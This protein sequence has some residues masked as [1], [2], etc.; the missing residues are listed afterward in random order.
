MTKKCY[1]CKSGN[2]TI[3]FKKSGYNIL[4]CKD[5]ALHFLDFSL[6]YESFIVDFYGAGY[7]Q[8]DKQRS[9][10]IDYE[11][12]SENVR[13]AARPVLKELF[14]DLK[15]RSIKQSSDSKFSLLDIGCANG[16]LMEEA[17]Q[18]GFNVYGIDVSDFAVEIAKKRF[19]NRVKCV[20][21]AKFKGGSIRYDAAVMFD[22]FEHLQNP[23]ENLKRLSG[24][25]ANNGLLAI[26][27]GDQGSLMAKIF[28]HRW[29]F[30]N[31]PQ[32]LFFMKLS[33]IKFLLEEAGFICKKV[34]RIGKWF[35]LRY[36]LH[37]ARTSGESRVAD[38]L[39]KLLGNTPIGRIPIYLKL[40]D[41]ILIIAQNS[42]KKFGGRLNGK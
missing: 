6:D 42:N 24:I 30:Y 21:L 32:H 14:K 26:R 35:E 22:V 39:Y 18:I 2:I 20:S 1:L 17:K 4:K 23:R 8:G 27:T 16:Y 5:C 12:E 9:A 36:I 40:Y 28:G 19:G 7:F 11:K 15:L 38:L 10:Y 3:A 37:I 25:L 33:H 41:T 29:H 34:K 31:P 13:A